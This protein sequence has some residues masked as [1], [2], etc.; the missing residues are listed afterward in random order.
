MKFLKYILIGLVGVL[1]FTSCDKEYLDTTPTDAYGDV[2]VFS[3]ADNAMVALNGIHRAM[4]TTY[5]SRQNQSGQNSMMINVDLLGEDLVMTTAGNGWFNN[6]YKWLDHRNSNGWLTYFPYQ[7]YY[8]IIGN[9]NTI[10]ANIDNTS[11]DPLLKAQVKGEA[12]AY[13]GWA[14]FNLIQLYAKRYDAAT[15]AT[16]PGVP[17]LIV[18][19][20]DPQPRATVAAVYE[21]I[22]ADLEASISLLSTPYKAY[23]KSHFTAPV[24][25]G[26]RARVALTMGDYPTAASFANIARTTTSASLMSNTQYKA[27][28]NDATNSEWM[29]ATIMI[30]DQQVYFYS[31][32]AYMSWNFNSTNIRG[33]PKAINSN[34]YN[35]ISATDVRKT[36]WEPAP[37]TVNFPLPS[38]S[39][40]RRPYMQRK[41]GVKDFTSS[42]G[43]IPYMRLAELFLIEAEA[44]AR[45]GAADAADVLYTLAVNRDPSYVKS[46]NTG[47]AL[48]QEI[49][50]QRRM[51]LWGEGF[52]FFDLKR[53]DLPLNRAGS[54]HNATLAVTM[55]VPAGD[56]RWQFLF[57][58]EEVNANPFIKDNQNP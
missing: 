54:N 32:F 39:Y 15:A 22:I 20:P 29:W 23:P 44:K 51:E 6:E 36:L 50:L 9:A 58:I 34:L 5:N 53:L 47:D 40:S 4:Y 48:V 33:N 16:A 28:F 8:K 1:G 21:Q 26:I 13:R 45:T 43:D 7:F 18:Q 55:D 10:I 38:T 30:A 37:T 35:L 46:T 25:N 42:V 24:V 52:R 56:N 41:F 17:L 27:G 57:P 12:L 2:F 3:T 31:Y 19:S 14:Y 11:G 49:L